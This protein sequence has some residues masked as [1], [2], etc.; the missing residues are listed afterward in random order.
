[1][2]TLIRPLAAEFLG[3]FTFVFVS[4]GAVVVD[5]AKSGELGLVGVALASAFAYAVAVTA[6]MSISGGHI[7][8]A[9]TFGLWVARKTEPRQAA[10]YVIAQLLGAVLAA[11]CVRA[12]LPEL[13][14]EVT[15]YGTPRISGLLTDAQAVGIEALLTFFL[16]GAV[17]GTAIS[18][19]AP[20][21]GGF[22][23]GLVL[24]FGIL[25][26]GP[27]TGAA[28]NP[29]RAFGPALVAGAWQAHLLY[30]VGPLLGALLAAVVWRWVLL[31]EADGAG[32]L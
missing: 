9:V 30:W 26:G 15:G 11:L 32:S 17:F 4:A 22:G 13:A 21:V 5:A 7:N 8:P 2:K 25:V 1:M 19:A 23:V 10:F 27:M 18:P 16:V 12:L 28:L 6:T 31:P 24:L 20:R 14:G 3:T 29:A